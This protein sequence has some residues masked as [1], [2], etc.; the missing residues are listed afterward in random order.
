MFNLDLEKAE[1][2]DIKLPTYGESKKKQDNSRKTPTSVSLTTLKPLAMWITTNW[3]ILKEMGIP[4]HITCFLRN[5]YT[6]QDAVVRTRQE[7]MDSFQ[8]G[9][10]IH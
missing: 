4:G 10:G 2:L 3:K 1:E 8:I 7:A 5:V 6:G 9:K